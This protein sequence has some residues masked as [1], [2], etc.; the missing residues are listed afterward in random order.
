MKKVRHK[1]RP[2]IRSVQVH[3]ATGKFIF[4]H[5]NVH[6]TT[7][8]AGRTSIDRIR[9]PTPNMRNRNIKVMET[10]KRQ[11]QN[12]LVLRRFQERVFKAFSLHLSLLRL[13]PCAAT[14][15]RICYHIYPSLLAPSPPSTLNA[16]LAHLVSSPVHRACAEAY[17]FPVYAFSLPSHRREVLRRDPHYSKPTICRGQVT[18][19]YRVSGPAFHD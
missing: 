18:R 19:E 10:S 9:F 5:K 6:Q 2:C 1:V 11:V 3:A 8:N 14:T 17:Y 15:N 16:L 7:S 13:N 4:N 12:M